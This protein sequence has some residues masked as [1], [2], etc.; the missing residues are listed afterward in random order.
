MGQRQ[1]Q[2]RPPCAVYVIGPSSSGKSTLC[3]ALA[4]RYNVV[5]P[6]YI[7][8]V[9]RAVMKEKG[10]TR[11][12]VERMDMQYA[13][14]KAQAHADVQAH[15]SVSRGE[16]PIV[17]SDRSVVDPIVYALL[18][19]PAEGHERAR[20]LINVTETQLSL[21]HLRRSTVILLA[22]VPEWVEDDGIRS[23]DEH[24][25]SIDAFRAVLQQLHIP[26]HEIDGTCRSLESRVQ[27]VSDWAGLTP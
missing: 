23:V 2:K 16:S 17:L 13:I 27:R 21:T 1:S 8:E 24:Y 9:A 15:N 14:L 4:K 7:K 19:S 6:A 22:P 5:A 25:A 12:D 11:E 18:S 26:F 10:F 3:D 20:T